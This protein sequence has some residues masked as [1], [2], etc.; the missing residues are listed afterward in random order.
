MS[1]AIV[2]FRNFV[3]LAC[4]LLAVSG[5]SKDA[6]VKFE[7][8]RDFYLV[9]QWEARNEGMS[10]PKS[11]LSSIET[12]N[13]SDRSLLKQSHFQSG[14][15]NVIRDSNDDVVQE[16]G[17]IFALYVRVGRSHFERLAKSILAGTTTLSDDRTL[18]LERLPALMDQ[19]ESF[20]SDRDLP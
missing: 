13:S 4:L 10:V 6:N 19:F 9:S 8:Y 3:A 20:I 12:F 1:N 16:S 14:I 17:P 11:V 2:K 5:C 18:L 15:R 7:K